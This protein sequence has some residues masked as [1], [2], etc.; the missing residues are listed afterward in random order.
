MSVA[1]DIF[2]PLRA[3]IIGSRSLRAF[4]R[5]KLNLAQRA[6]IYVTNTSTC[7]MHGTYHIYCPEDSKLYRRKS[8]H[9]VFDKKTLFFV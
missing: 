9:T 3:A 8:Y 2:P 4:S 6:G 5:P 1:E 7:I